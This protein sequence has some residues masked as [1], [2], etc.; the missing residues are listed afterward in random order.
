MKKILVFLIIIFTS[1]KN[2][3]KN[4]FTTEE[5]ITN[6]S[7]SV[8]LNPKVFPENLIVKTL[9]HNLILNTKMFDQYS[10]KKG[11]SANIKPNLKNTDFKYSDY[12][13]EK[14]EKSKFEDP[15]TY[16]A[17]EILKFEISFNCNDCYDAMLIRYIFNSDSLPKEKELIE[18]LNDPI[19]IDRKIK[20]NEENLF[21]RTEEISLRRNGLVGFYLA[22]RDKNKELFMYE[23][24]GI[25]SD[26][27]APVFRESEYC[28]FDGDDEY[29]GLVCLTT[30]DFEGNDYSG[31]SV[32]IKGRIYGDVTEIKIN[33]KSVKFKKGE[34]Y[35]RI[36]MM[37]K[38]GYNQIP[39]VLKDKYGNTNETYMEV[40]LSR[41]KEEPTIDIDIENNN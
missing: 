9:S 1:C 19:S 20:R 28:S 12:F 23:L 39:V 35:K 8:V 37:L 3:S 29:E 40:T 6:E 25:K 2:N 22:L 32:P 17:D 11:E 38:T 15:E 34:F 13:L 33:G 31:Y 41:I 24:A 26:G 21:Q 36:H 18:F 14:L 27:L 4:D 16:G 30:K 10:L 5:K 7:K